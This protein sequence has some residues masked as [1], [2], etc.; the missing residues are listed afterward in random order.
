MFSIKQDSTRQFI[1]WSVYTLLIIN[2]VFYFAEDWS[3]AMHTLDAESTL[4]DWTS[5]FATTIDESAWFLL[6][7]LLELETYVLNKEKWRDW[8]STLMH[9]IRAACLIMIAHTLVA[10]VDTVIDYEKVN[11]VENVTEL[12]ELSNGNVSYVYN[13]EYTEVNEITCK[14]LSAADQ[15]FWLG[16]DPLVSDFEGLQLAQN[17]A[18]ADVIEVIVWLLI[19][20]AIEATVRLQSGSITNGKWIT[21]LGT[22]KIVSYTILLGLG[23][24]WGYLSHWLYTWDTILWIGGFTAIDANLSMVKSK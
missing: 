23:A 4:Y 21:R 14:N 19:L 2:F 12:C 3:R 18:W 11:I 6:L 13:L 16:E 15:F 7:F 9:W 1:K 24:Y 5:E 20:L 8:L 22:I 10:V 17:L